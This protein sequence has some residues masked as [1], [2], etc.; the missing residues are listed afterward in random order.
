KAA[1]NLGRI[2]MQALPLV[3]QVLSYLERGELLEGEG[4]AWVYSL[5]KKSE[6]LLRECR[7]WLAESYEAQGK[8]LQAGL[9]YRAMTQSLP[10]DEEGLQHWISML[11][12]QGKM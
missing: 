10:P 1:E 2:S 7:L 3:E 6:D 12:R 8:L 9:Q 5:R 4:G 11:H